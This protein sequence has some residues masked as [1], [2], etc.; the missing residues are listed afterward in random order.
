MQPRLVRLDAL[1]AIANDLYLSRSF[2]YASDCRLKKDFTLFEKLFFEKFRHPLLTNRFK[3]LL[4]DYLLGSIS[5]IES[6]EIGLEHLCLLLTFGAVVGGLSFSQDF[7]FWSG[8]Q[9]SD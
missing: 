6:V 3:L 1:L 9:S 2:R 4:F 5:F 7:N 8:D